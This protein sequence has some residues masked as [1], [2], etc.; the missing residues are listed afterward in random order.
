MQSVSSSVLSTVPA[1]SLDHRSSYEETWVALN[2]EITIPTEKTHPNFPLWR[3]GYTPEQVH[4]LF[5]PKQFRFLCNPKRPSVCGRFG[6][7]TDRLWRFEFVVLPGEDGHK[8]AS[9]EEIRKIIYPYI[10]HPGKRYGLEYPVRFPEDC[11]KT[12]RSR[13]FSFVARSC[14]LWSL[15]RT[16]L[17]GDA[18][19][20]FP[21]FGMCLFRCCVCFEQ[22]DQR[23]GGQGIASG[24]RDASALAWRLA[25][26]RKRPTAD[27][28]ALLTGWYTE[29]K[30]QLE[31]SLAATIQ[32]GEYVTESDPIK[33]FI[34][35]W[36]MW[37]V[38]LVPSWK[39]ELQKGARALGMT[40][41]QYSPGL[42]F[43]DSTVG[44]LQLPQVY[45]FNFRTGEVEFTDDLIFSPAKKGLF[46]LLVLPDDVGEVGL[47]AQGL[48][49]INCLSENLLFA[50]EATFLV[51]S[52]K[53]SIAANDI[54]VQQEVARIATGEEFAVAPVLCKDRPPPVGYDELRLRKEVKGKKFLI[55]RPDRFIFAACDSVVELKAAVSKLSGALHLR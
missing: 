53:T 24:F 11:I 25:L 21:P 7:K 6:L 13:P 17:C 23:T 31:R 47:L 15:G 41:Y 50:E 14:N 42:A 18:A 52:T 20:V 39:R 43:I 44:G 51:Q 1:C 49:D 4:D 2:W 27:H 36:Y 26:L 55:V 3:L 54:S 48:E 8:M 10:T 35:E 5:F 16:I 32:N 28:E 38:Q 30:Q 12:L 40:K 37:A 45:A 34:R 22:A 33:V 29:R 9:L 19:H 46:Q